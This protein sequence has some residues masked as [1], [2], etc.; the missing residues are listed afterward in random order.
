MEERNLK[1]F[2]RPHMMGNAQEEEDVHKPLRINVVNF[3]LNHA[4]LFLHTDEMVV[5]TVD[6]QRGYI[7]TLVVQLVPLGPHLHRVLQHIAGDV[8]RSLLGDARLALLVES[9]PAIIII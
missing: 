8:K 7:D 4:L 6:E 9:I 3:H 2:R 1:L 5:A